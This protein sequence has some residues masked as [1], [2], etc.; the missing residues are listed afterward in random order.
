MKK[1]LL[2]ITSLIFSYEVYASKARMTALGQDAS[3]GSFYLE[4]PRNLFRNPSEISSISDFAIVEAADSA[5]PDTGEGNIPVGHGEGAEGG[6]FKK[7]SDS[8]SVG[9]YI[10]NALN[11]NSSKVGGSAT[12]YAADLGGTTA[13]SAPSTT[14]AAGNENLNLFIGGEAG[15]KWGV[16]ISQASAS[17][18]TPADSTLPEYEKKHSLL[19]IGIGISKDKMKAYANVDL[20]D[21][22]EGGTVS[23][24][25]AY[26]KDDLVEGSWK[27]LGASMKVKDLVIF[28]DY[29]H[30]KVEATTG[31][32]TKV[33][34]ETSQSV[35]TIGSSY[36]KPVSESAKVNLDISFKKT[37]AKDKNGDSSVVDDKDIEVKKTEMPLVIGFEKQ[38]TSWLALRASVKQNVLLGKIEESGNTSVANTDL[39]T[40]SSLNGDTSVNIGMGLTFDELIIDGTLGT[41]EGGLVD[42]RNFGGR[43]GVSYFF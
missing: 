27:N 32:A 11:N 33:V 28:A 13:Y 19:G 6:F 43:V 8:M 9:V 23:T 26:E 21:K 12:G 15:V 10:G 24:A 2:I 14:Q 36:I 22:Y 42:S 39:N 7:M 37:S 16:R 3:L 4:D 38:A 5:T 17:S 31:G 29:D 41:S 34:D 40:E 25:S 20:K 18:K 30:R 1:T 35:I